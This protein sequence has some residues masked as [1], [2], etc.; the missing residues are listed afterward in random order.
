LDT[1]FDKQ[2]HEE[3]TSELEIIKNTIMKNAVYRAWTVPIFKDGNL[4]DELELFSE[5]YLSG[6]SGHGIT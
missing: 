2:Q 1:F 6:L 4:T 3:A 5:K